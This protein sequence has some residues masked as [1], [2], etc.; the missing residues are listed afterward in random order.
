MISTRCRE[1]RKDSSVRITRDREIEI[2]CGREKYDT[3]KY[4]I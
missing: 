2:E 1:E 3:K 4:I